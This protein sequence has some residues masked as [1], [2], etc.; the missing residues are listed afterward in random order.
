MIPVLTDDRLAALDGIR[1]GFFTRQGGVSAG[2]YASLNC[3]VGSSDDR[4]AELGNRV[5]VADAIGVHADRLATPY[6]VHGSDVVTVSDV[7][8]PGHGPHADAVVTDRPGVALGVGTAD[9]GP[10]LL[11]D[12]AAGV[13]GCTSRCTTGCGPSRSR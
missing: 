3:G 7:W 5:R 12:V 10:V 9:C 1:H 11:A 2:V 13:V 8:A 4:T 6:Q